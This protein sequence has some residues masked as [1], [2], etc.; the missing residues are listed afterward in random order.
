MPILRIHR[1]PVFAVYLTPILDE[2]LSYAARGVYAKIMAV[3]E[4][5]KDYNDDE[6]SSE[7]EDCL[8]ELVQAKYLIRTENSDGSSL[9][10]VVSFPSCFE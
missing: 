6:R 2:A 8:E 1:A 10:E 9:Y 5:G 3:T 4:T 7:W